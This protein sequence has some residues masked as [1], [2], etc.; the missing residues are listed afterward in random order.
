MSADDFDS[1]K[2]L[3]DG[4]DNEIAAISLTS[5]MAGGQTTTPSHDSVQQAKKA[6]NTHL[7]NSEYAISHSFFN[8]PS[9][10]FHVRAVRDYMDD[11]GFL[12]FSF[13]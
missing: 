13:I 6:V 11:L 8:T 5:S 3:L 10:P 1:L 12:F 4:L 7:L 2:D 9:L